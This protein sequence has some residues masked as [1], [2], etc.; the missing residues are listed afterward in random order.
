MT[1]KVGDI[2]GLIKGMPDELVIE[3]IVV[4]K[5]SDVRIGELVMNECVK[6]VKFITSN[7]VRVKS[8]MTDQEIDEMLESESK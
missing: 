1:V 4:Y 8:L 7:D 3:E 6:R 2:K 5:G